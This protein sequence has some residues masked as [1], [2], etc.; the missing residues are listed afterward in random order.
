M[1]PSG[2]FRLQV[3]SFTFIIIKTHGNALCGPRMQQRAYIERKDKV[4]GTLHSERCCIEICICIFEIQM[5]K[6]WWASLHFAHLTNIAL[7]SGTE[8]GES[9]GACA[10]LLPFPIPFPSSTSVISSKRS[11]YSNRTVTYP[12]KTVTYPETEFVIKCMLNF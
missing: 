9:T 12:N 2:E 8:P 1:Q 5:S 7:I 10:P 3:P 4:R 6:F 11:K